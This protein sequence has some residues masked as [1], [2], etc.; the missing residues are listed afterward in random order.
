MKSTRER[1]RFEITAQALEAALTSRTRALL[2]NTPWN[3]V[4][5]VFTRAELMQIADF[6]NRRDL[7]LISDE[8]YET[9][10]YDGHLHL[11]PL[12]SPTRCDSAVLL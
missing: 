12:R 8:I 2:L 7:M 3:P 11:S 5:S 1:G 9:I 4:G 10:T 6:V